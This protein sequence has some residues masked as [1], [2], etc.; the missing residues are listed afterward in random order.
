M[1]RRWERKAQPYSVQDP[2]A[3]PTLGRQYP[4]AGAPSGTEQGR[5]QLYL[6]L[7]R[8]GAGCEGRGGWCGAPAASV[9]GQPACSVAGA[10]LALGSLRP[11][12]ALMS[13]EEEPEAEDWESR[14]RALSDW[15]RAP[16]VLRQPLQNA[17]LPFVF[18][19]TLVSGDK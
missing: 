1:G 9:P 18:N 19:R 8:V 14:G 2:G 10:W 4:V 16:V 15:R 6:R 13:M 3:P 5:P 11:P 7:P 12:A 17:S